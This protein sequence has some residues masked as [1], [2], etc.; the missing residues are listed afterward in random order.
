MFKYQVTYTSSKLLFK[1]H[2]FKFQKRRSASEIKWFF[3]QFWSI[4]SGAI[5]IKTFCQFFGLLSNKLMKK[6]EGFRDFV[7]FKY[8]ERI[9][10]IDRTQR[11]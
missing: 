9:C 5:L 8:M 7:H 2:V 3:H 10:S 6:I 11:F 1:H 4:E